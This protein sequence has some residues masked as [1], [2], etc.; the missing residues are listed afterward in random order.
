MN[1]PWRSSRS[2]HAAQPRRYVFVSGHPRSGT[3]WVSQLL[4]LHPEAFCD[5]E[6]HFL[7]L[8][9]A[10]D[11]FTSLRWY[12]GSG[13]PTRSVAER[14][15]QQLIRDCLDS[16]AIEKGRGGASVVGDHTP[17][18][19]RIMI[20]PPEARYIVVQRD[21][22]DVLVSYTFHLLNAKAAEVVHESVREAFARQLRTIDGSP[23]AHRAAARWLLDHEP[24]VRYYANFWGDQILHDK[25]IFE[26]V[27]SQGVGQSVMFVSYEALRA[28]TQEIRADMYRH[29][30]LDPAKARPLSPDTHTSPGFGGREDVTSFY[31]KGETGDWRN[32]FTRTTA[33]AFH[34]AAHGAMAHLGYERDDSWVSSIP[35]PRP[36]DRPDLVPRSGAPPALHPTAFSP[37]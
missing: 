36:P 5:G 32:Y 15:L 29:L 33:A 35:E 21:G 30:G 16:R 10:M 25:R 28:N 14:G 12:M 2:K 34:A 11:G 6:F 9:W 18:L 23:Q 1:L 24:W 27:A 22:R 17:R 37:G 26:G 8:R 7:I 31:R 19:F 20:S 13:E 3:N 4:N